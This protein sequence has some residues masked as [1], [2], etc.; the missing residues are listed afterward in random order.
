MPPDTASNGGIPTNG[1]LNDGLPYCKVR[2]AH[3]L[4]WDISG[5]IDSELVGSTD[6]HSS[7]PQGHESELWEGC[8]ESRRCSQACVTKYTSMRRSKTITRWTT[9]L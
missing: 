8:R 6:S 3:D 1:A 5:L 7:H 2:G 9:T 4:L